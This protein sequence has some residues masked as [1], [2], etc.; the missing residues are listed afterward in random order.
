MIRK[1]AELAGV[2]FERHPD[3]RVPLDSLILEEAADDPASLP[4][5][6]FTLDELWRRRTA[7]GL[8][9][10]EAY[11]RLGGLSGGIARRAE[12]VVRELEKK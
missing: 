2:R 4:L 5:L 12:E 8:I 10:Y 6:E 7:E 3:T 9:S 1:P 11:E